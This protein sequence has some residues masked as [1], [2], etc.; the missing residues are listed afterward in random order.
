[1]AFTAFPHTAKTVVL[2]DGTK[3]AVVH[4]AAKESNPTFLLLHGFPSSSYDW[5]HQISYLSKAGYGVVAPDL[6]GYGDSDQPE[7]LEAY[8]F[9][10]MSAHIVE[11]LKNP[12]IAK[13]IAVAHDW[14][15]G[16]QSHVVN[17]YPY[18][19]SG[20]IYL[21]VGY[22]PPG[23]AVSIDAVNELTEKIFGYPTYGYW[24]LFTAEDGAEVLNNN[25]ESL[26]SLF[27]PQEP[28]MWKE[29]LGP[30][31]A[32]RSWITSGKTTPLPSWMSAEEHAIH[33]KLF[34]KRGYGPGLNWYKSGV[35][36][37]GEDKVELA[38]EQ[39]F[40]DV[41][42]LL[43]VSTKDYITRPEMAV[44]QT[45]KYVRNL[46]VESLECGHWIQLEVPDE[47]NNLISRFAQGLKESSKM[48]LL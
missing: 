9:Q 11:V 1:M 23:S 14:G 48:A 10:R 36:G 35:R 3:Y 34:E 38:E 39:K 44:Q 29:H 43:I 25:R 30:L 20:A 4:I 17:E 6:L 26:F 33:A 24:K 31:G 41:P 46:K 22:Y 42:S 7:S 32:A 27:Y 5:R 47:V 15:C 16:L 40:S 2:A 45:Q 8:A 13:V 37:P 21:S 28:E 18:L 12:G 19:F